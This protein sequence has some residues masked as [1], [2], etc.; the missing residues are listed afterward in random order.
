MAGQSRTLKLSILADVD[1]L[2][3]SLKAAN[4]D[5]E[6]SASK[7]GDFGKKA[8]LAFAAAGAA[9]AAYAVKLAVD[10][11]K[12]A[13]EDEQAQIKL[14][15]ALRNA[16]GAT[17]AQIAAT[18]NYI[19]QTSLATGVTDDKLRPAL[20]RLALSTN[21]ITKAQDLLTL[22]IDIST[23]S[24]KP[25]EGVANSLGKAYDGNTAALG[26]LGIGLSSA[27]LKS[28]S[29]KEVQTKLSELFGG[30]AAANA[31]TYAGKI[32]KLKVGFNEAKET[33]GFALLP[34]V[35]KF[36]NFLNLSALPSLD[37]VIAGFSGDTGFSNALGDSSSTAFKLGGEIKKLTGTFDSFFQVFDS[38]GA[39]SLSGFL[40]V[41]TGL[42]K[43]I[44]I[45]LAPFRIALDLIIRSINELL[46]ALNRIPGVDLKLLNP[47]IPLPGDKN[48]K[49]P[50]YSSIS[51]VLGGSVP[52]IK[53]APV[54]PAAPSMAGVVKS[55]GVAA[56][57]AEVIPFI[58]L[59]YSDAQINRKLDGGGIAA[60]NITVN[61]AIDPIGTARTIYQVLGGEATTSGSF[62]N[63]GG[64][65]VV[66]P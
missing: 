21:D 8:A 57:A 51:G 58:D 52:T 24:G 29:F 30:A 3:K 55:A 59:K 31:E 28:M 65:R 10:G 11:V 9:A 34:Q 63:L 27:E 2:N 14:A 40:G 25:L 60:V 54:L 42:I 26:K 46:S 20:A 5:V 23:Q 18:E 16:T 12:A 37:L 45:V 56:T 15:T 1:Q 7:I 35:E 32:A 53:S 62:N 17:D 66:A 4:N 48:Y 41:V 33:L 49:A 39:S 13:I 19:L 36:I 50:T 22:A 6:D 47:V 64:S 43:G 61:G 38:S 44:T